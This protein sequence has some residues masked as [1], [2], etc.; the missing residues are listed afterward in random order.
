VACFAISL[1]AS[2]GWLQPGIYATATIGSAIAVIDASFG[3]HAIRSKTAKK[4]NTILGLDFA[5]L[6][7]L[8]AATVCLKE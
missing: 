7:G 3:W 1:S 4:R 6:A 8:V 2:V 5:G